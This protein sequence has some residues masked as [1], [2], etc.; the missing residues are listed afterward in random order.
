MWHSGV[1]SQSFM[2]K[3][4]TLYKANFSSGAY[5]TLISYGF[6]HHDLFHFLMNMVG[7]WSFGKGIEVAFGASK[8]LQLYLGGTIL[9]GMLQMRYSSPYNPTLGASAAT[10]SMLAFYIL[11]FPRNTIFIYFI[12][13]P[14]WMI[15]CAFVSYTFY[16]MS[17]N[18]S[19]GIGHAAHL[20][21]LFAGAAL[22]VIS[23]GRL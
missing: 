15:G 5:H 20:G 9:G 16:S 18:S 4:F 8:L 19:R 6:S 10:C 22:Y 2:V 3:H 14:A 7:L 12:P 11:N 17:T 1:F 21:G 23:R 13:L